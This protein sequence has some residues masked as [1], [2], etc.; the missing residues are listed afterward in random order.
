MLAV[1]DEEE[2]FRATN[3]VD[4]GLAAYVFTDNLSAAYRFA[5]L[6][7]SGMVHINHGTASE[8]HIPFGGFKQSSY[9]PYSIGSSNMEFFTEMKVMYFQY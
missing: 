3:A 2:S 6:S 8:A 5:E 7:E 9:G 4:Y 1:A